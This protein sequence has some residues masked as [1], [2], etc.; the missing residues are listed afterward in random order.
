MNEEIRCH[1]PALERVHNGHPVAYFDGPGGTQV[2]NLV[3]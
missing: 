1:F 2:L 3:G